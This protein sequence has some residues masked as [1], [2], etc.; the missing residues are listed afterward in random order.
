VLL[1]GTP[2]EKIAARGEPQAAVARGC[3]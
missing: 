1:V 3:K 2:R